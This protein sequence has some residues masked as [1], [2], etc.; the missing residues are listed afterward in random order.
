MYILFEVHYFLHS[1]A[2]TILTMLQTKKHP[3]EESVY[4]S[5]CSTTDL[6]LQI[7]MNN[8]RYL[9]ECDFARFKFWCQ[10]GMPRASREQNAKILLGG[11][12]IRYR[13][14]LQLF[15]TFRIKSKILWWDEKAFI[16]EQK[17]ERTQDDFVCAIMLA[18]QSVVNSTPEKLLREIVGEE[19]QR[20]ECPPDVQKWIECNE[21]SSRNL[22]K[23]D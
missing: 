9:R 19:I 16:L 13:R 18:K 5:I 15:D 3:L 10:C 14:P 17:I 12:T 2:I 23:I 7:H 20:P 1:I 22:R 11:A 21:I 6:D 4:Y 8:A